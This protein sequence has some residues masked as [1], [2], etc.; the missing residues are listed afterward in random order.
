MQRVEQARHAGATRANVRADRF[1][2][3]RGGRRAGSATA[4]REH[5]TARVRRRG[6]R[7]VPAGRRCRRRRRRRS[8]PRRGRPRPPLPNPSSISTTSSNV[9]STPST[10]AS[11]SA[12]ARACA[13]SSASCNASTRACAR[14]ADSD[15][16]WR[17]CVARSS[18]DLCTASLGRSA[19]STSVTSGVST[20]SASAHSPRSRSVSSASCSQPRH[21]SHRPSCVT[22]R[23][24][25]SLRSTPFRID[26]S[27]PR[28]SAA[29]LAALALAPASVDAAP[30]RTAHARQR[31]RCSVGVERLGLGRHR[32]ERSRSPRRARRG[33][34]PHQPRGWRRRRRRAAGP[35]SRSSDRLRSARMPASPRAR[36]RSCSTCTSRSLT[37]LSPRADSCAS[38]DMISV[39]SRA[40]SDLSSLSE[41]RPLETRSTSIDS[42]LRRKRADLAAGDEHAQRGELG[43]EL[44]VPSRRLGLALE[45]AE[46]A[47]NLAQQVLQAQQVGLGGIEPAL[48]LLLALAVLEDACRFLDDA[49]R[50]SGRALSTASIWPWLTITCCWRP[51]PASDNSSWRSSS[52]HGAPL[53][54]YSLSPLRNRMRVSVT[55]LN[56]T[57]SSPDE[58]SSVRLD[59]GPAERRTLL[60]AGE[61]DVVH[62]LRADGS[63]RLRA[64]HP[65]DGIDDVGLAGTVGTDHHRHPWFEGQRGRVRERLEALEGETL[66]KHGGPD[67]TG[68]SR[69]RPSSRRPIRAVQQAFSAGIEGSSGWSVGP[70]SCGGSSRCRRSGSVRRRGR[71]P[72]EPPGTSPI[73]RTRS[74]YWLSP[75][76]EPPAAIAAPSTRWIAACNRFSAVGPSSSDIRSGRS[77]DSCRISSA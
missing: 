9:P 56:S 48:G 45:R 76:V 14:D 62:L 4:D 36:S 47:A 18:V 27:S 43:D 59:L 28:T 31:E 52:R 75:R 7:R 10:P 3:R 26:R 21:A 13:A 29:A 5:R 74:T 73:R 1:A 44:L 63:R 58:L 66:Q 24:S 53:I 40:R 38:N 2:D 60:G 64:E 57:G 12:P 37:S 61:D 69:R 32:L 17:A 77:R 16:S 25:L 51:T 68:P 71:R 39:S 41:L 22:R 67:A 46:L 33:S 23:S 49:R 11:R 42:S 70:R 34:A 54:A 65:G 6:A 50:S 20:D 8:A 35:W 55:S 72:C 30:R 19:C 15:A